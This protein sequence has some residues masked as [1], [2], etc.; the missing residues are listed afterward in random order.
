MVKDIVFHIGDCKTGTT[1]IQTMLARRAWTAAPK[2]VCYSARLNHNPIASKLRQGGE[3]ARKEGAKIAE[4]FRASD[5]DIG[6]ISA[7][8]F[9]FCDPE[10]LLRLVEGPLADWSGNIRL[11]QFV[12]PHIDRFRATFIERCK[13]GGCLDDI[14]TACAGIL[15][16][17]LLDYAPRLARWHAA[18]GTAITTQAYVPDHFPNRDVRAAL[19]TEL[20]GTDAVAPTD[21]TRENQSLSLQQ[22]VLLRYMH[23]EM[24]LPDIARDGGRAFGWNFGKILAELETTNPQPLTLPETVV[25]RLQTRC[26]TDAANVDGILG[27]SVF[28]SEL[29]RQTGS[30]ETQSLRPEDHFSLDT[31]QVARAYARLTTRL[32]QSDPSHFAWAA[33]EEEFRRSRPARRQLARQLKPKSLFSRLS[34]LR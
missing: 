21:I 27:G 28:A 4:D 23:A 11:I 18:F 15:D 1:S 3:L 22:V 2:T 16:E 25:E 12:R 20:F 24:A 10:V 33:R 14:E 26:R 8:H 34:L 13:K 30:A 32:I 31:L 9:E 7:E 5:A 17:G 19:L 29:L 6:V